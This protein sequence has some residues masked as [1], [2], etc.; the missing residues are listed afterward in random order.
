MTY[1][2][3]KLIAIIY[4]I[5]VIP[6]LAYHLQVP[7]GRITMFITANST[8][9]PTLDTNPWIGGTVVLMRSIFIWVFALCI[10]VMLVGVSVL[11]IGYLCMGIAKGIKW[12]KAG[13]PLKQ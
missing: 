7:F 1:R 8:E 10:W 9:L 6:I 12:I 13:E 3:L 11:A 4:G 5:I 2:L